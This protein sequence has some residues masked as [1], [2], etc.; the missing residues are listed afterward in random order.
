MVFVGKKAKVDDLSSDF[1]LKGVNCQVN[2]N[3]YVINEFCLPY[4]LLKMPF[5]A[6]ASFP[7]VF[8]VLTFFR[9]F[10]ETG[11]KVIESKPWTT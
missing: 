11:S 1:V 3:T 8:G 2:E 9:A 6:F 5:H 10:M 4:G 7:M